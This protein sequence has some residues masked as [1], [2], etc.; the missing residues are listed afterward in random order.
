MSFFLGFAQ[1]GAH[2][3]GLAMLQLIEHA[4]NWAFLTL[5]RLCRTVKLKIEPHL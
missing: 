1:G 5:A 4:W 2:L 3:A